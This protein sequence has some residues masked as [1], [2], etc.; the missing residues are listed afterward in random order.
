[1]SVYVDQYSGPE[2]VIYSKYAFVLKYFYLSI[3]FGAVLP[4]VFPI[5][6]VAMLNQYLMDKVSLAYFYKAP[7]HYDARIGN[8]VFKLMVGAPFCGL[9]FTY[10]ALGNPAMFSNIVE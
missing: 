9:T 1:M 10:W 4:I 3:I 5:A 7:P 8:Q 6:F 2:Y